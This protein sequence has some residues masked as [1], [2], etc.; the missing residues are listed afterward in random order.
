M[1]GI[2][3]LPIKTMCFFMGDICVRPRKGN[4]MGAQF[5]WSPLLRKTTRILT[6]LLIISIGVFFAYPRNPY[7]GGYG[8]PNDGG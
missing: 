5:G 1:M 6:L 4:K 3:T 2:R 7:C 8:H